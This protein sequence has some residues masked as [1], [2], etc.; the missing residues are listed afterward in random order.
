L[1]NAC[2]LHALCRIT[3]LWHL[4][5]RLHKHHRHDT[6]ARASNQ[7]KHK[8][9]DVEDLGYLGLSYKG[10]KLAQR[11]HG[12]YESN[13]IQHAEAKE[14]EHSK[15]HVIHIFNLFVFR[16]NYYIKMKK[17]NMKNNY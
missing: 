9:G 6:K 8:Y 17:L 10:W 4:L 3:R 14:G 13:E 2:F 12:P 7:T 11:P 15:R 1:Q 16:F 5:Q